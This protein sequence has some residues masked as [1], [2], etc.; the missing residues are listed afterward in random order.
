LCNTLRLP[1]T[2]N[3]PSCSATSQLSE[4]L[5]RKKNSIVN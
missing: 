3:T 1:C 5:R 2:R 4:Y